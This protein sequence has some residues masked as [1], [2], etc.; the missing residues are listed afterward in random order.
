[1]ARNAEGG[2]P[3]KLIFLINKIETVMSITS[4]L[5]NLRVVV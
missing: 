2:V 3:Y 1:M 4:L 5:T